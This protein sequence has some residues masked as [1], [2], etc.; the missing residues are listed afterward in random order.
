MLLL[1]GCG[2]V[3]PGVQP[4]AAPGAT[5][6]LADATAAAATAAA[7]QTAACPDAPGPVEGQIVFGA[8]N[9][10]LAMRE[11]GSGVAALTA[12]PEGLW[13]HDPAWSPDGTTLAF[14]LDRPSSDPNLQGLALGTVC[15]LDRRTGK[16]RVLARGAAPNDSLQEPA[17]TPDGRALLVTL[18]Q[19]R[20]DPA[21]QLLNDPVAVA[22]YDL[23][24]GAI[25]PL[26]EDA[27]SPTPS[28]DGQQLAYV[29]VELATGETKLMF[30]RADGQE[31]RPI[32]QPK[33]ALTGIA[34]P[35]WSPDGRQVVFTASG[36]PTSSTSEPT[37]PLS[38]LDR[39]LGITVAAAHGLPAHL[40]TASP[41]DH[42]LLRLTEQALD[43][44][45]AAWSP[46]GRRLAY[47]GGGNGGVYLLDL[48]NGDQ[49]RLTEQGD[50]GGI[51]WATR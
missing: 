1:L 37:A 47:T 7:L 48:A 44:P 10:L 18:H 23:E 35:R 2:A 17:W 25:Q 4:D 12:L 26:V 43:D 31:A 24:T 38:L 9:N 40:W 21:T 41:D 20:I 22:R 33:E 8:G 19:P 32:D 34:A 27:T 45:R 15:G 49:Q 5:A 3:A 16:G 51:A 42:G 39:F 11:D 36:S 6:P 13:A 14:T 46:D 50:Y 28:P 29:H 30:A